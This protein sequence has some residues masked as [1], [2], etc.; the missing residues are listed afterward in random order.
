[1]SADFKVENH[2]HCTLSAVNATVHYKSWTGQ[3]SRFVAGNSKGGIRF[4]IPNIRHVANVT[5][6]FGGVWHSGDRD[7]FEMKYADASNGAFCLDT[8]V[9]P[10]ADGDGA[11]PLTT[12]HMY[13]YGDY[14]DSN[15]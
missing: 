3:Q 4:S 6:S 7:A 5:L 15:D 10:I 14:C 11:G 12:G 8:S 13:I 9:E 2:G 1:M